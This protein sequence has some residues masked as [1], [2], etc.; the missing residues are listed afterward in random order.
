M[1]MKHR[2]WHTWRRQAGQ[3]KS[4]AAKMA[5]AL[6]LFTASTLRCTFRG[7]R[8][9]AGQ[10]QVHRAIML[11]IAGRILHRTMARVRALTP[12][13]HM[14]LLS[15]DAPLPSGQCP[16]K[17][18]KERTPDPCAE[19]IACCYG[20]VQ[21]MQVHMLTK[22]NVHDIQAFEA[23]QQYAWN[24]QRLQEAAALVSGA[25]LNRTLRSAFNT[26]LEHVAHR[27]D[28]ERLHELADR[29]RGGFQHRALRAAFNTWL[30]SAQERGQ[31][32]RRQEIVEQA[33]RAMVNR[34]ARAAFNSWIAFTQ[35]SKESKHTVR[36]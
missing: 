26:W 21:Y 14:L 30:E 10:A 34:L 11:Q 18:I 25:M 7:W 6:L 16:A 15:N 17:H 23:W 12:A 13:L 1:Q 36:D 24:K 9:A 3:M 29:A 31:E 5:R 22:N 20:S 8:L 4:D 35:Q 2:T 28:S 27:R 32:R 19:C 33:S